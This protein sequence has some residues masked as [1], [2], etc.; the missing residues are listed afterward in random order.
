MW[1]HLRIGTGPSVTHRLRDPDLIPTTKYSQLEQ[2]STLGLIP[3]VPQPARD[4]HSQYSIKYEEQTRPYLIYCRE[5]SSQP[6][7]CCC[8][9]VLLSSYC[10][11]KPKHFWWPT[12]LFLSVCVFQSVIRCLWHPKLNQI[13][14]GTGNGLAK[15]YYDPVKS[16][17]YVW[18]LGYYTNPF[19]WRQLPW[20]D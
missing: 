1:S 6:A 7:T 4:T 13:M 2:Q 15:V 12:H 3:T 8:F 11:E 18:L 20:R 19:Y 10:A 9:K 16:H 14:V 5:N 17:R